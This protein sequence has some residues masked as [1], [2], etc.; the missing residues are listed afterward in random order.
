MK[1]L[2][3]TRKLIAHEDGEEPYEIDGFKLVKPD[4]VTLFVGQKAITLPAADIKI[5]QQ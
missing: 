1:E 4:G 3:L 5:V 2:D